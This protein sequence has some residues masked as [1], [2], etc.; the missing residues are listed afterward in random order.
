MTTD[1]GTV[2]LDRTKLTKAVLDKA[3]KKYNEEYSG[4]DSKNMCLFETTK[5][6]IADTDKDEKTITISGETDVGTFWLTVTI[7]DD[8]INDFVKRRIEKLMKINEALN[9]ED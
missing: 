1:C 5:M 2:S 9:A 6:E 8:T 4:E 7:D 3:E